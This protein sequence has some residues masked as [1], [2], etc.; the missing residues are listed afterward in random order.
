MRYGM[1]EWQHSHVRGC[2]A[3]LFGLFAEAIG[4]SAADAVERHH[5]TRRGTAKQDDRA[6]QGNTA[7]RHGGNTL[8]DDKCKVRQGKARQRKARQGKARQGKARQGKARQGKATHY[9]TR[10]KIKR[11]SDR[12]IQTDRQTQQLSRQ[13]ARQPARQTDRKS[14]VVNM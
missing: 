14:Y 3:L 12:G 6:S 2:W 1:I 5:K 11:K 10:E 13:L 9:K 4:V 8:H 7:V